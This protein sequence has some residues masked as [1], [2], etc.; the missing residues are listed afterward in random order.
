ME[1][2][3]RGL[4]RLKKAIR[5][6]E[7]EMRAVP[8]GETMFPLAEHVDD[9]DSRAKWRV[10]SEIR[11][12]EKALYNR[13]GNEPFLANAIIDLVSE[14]S[15]EIDWSGLLRGLERFLDESS[16]WIVAIPLSNAQTQGYTPITEQ[17]GLAEVLQDQNWERD[18]EPPVEIRQIFNHLDDYIDVGVRW[19]RGAQCGED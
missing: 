1:S 9:Q 19:H 12:R 3:P 7:T 5:R 16:D 6:A 18:S 11:F 14:S 8:A 15:C 17:V 10:V 4:A 2:D 13:F